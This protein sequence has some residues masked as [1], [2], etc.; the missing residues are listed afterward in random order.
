MGCRGGCLVAYGLVVET[1]AS[2]DLTAS[3]PTFFHRFTMDAMVELRAIRTWVMKYGTP[4]MTDLKMELRTGYDAT[5]GGRLLL[6]T[7]TKQ[8]AIGDI[9]S[10]T[11]AAKEIWFNWD[12]APLLKPG[13]E[14]TLNLKSAS[15]FAD[16][17]N[18]IAWRRTWPDP[19]VP[20]TGS[21]S[22]QN[23]N[24]FPFEVGLITREVRR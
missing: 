2:A 17:S 5:S 6:A 22:Y 10:S 20:F 24:R 15:Y 23:L 18:F 11:Y 19:I 16:A 1:L 14:Y 13:V 21:T 8:W 4:T 12:N 3:V 7:S 9:S